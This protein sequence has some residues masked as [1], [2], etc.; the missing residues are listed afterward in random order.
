MSG[1]RTLI[2]ALRQVNG[3]TL[4]D[5]VQMILC[6]V[7]SVNEQEN[8]CD[9]IQ[10]SGD[11]EVSIPNVRLQAD[12]SDGILYL[13]AID[14]TVIVVISDYVT[15]FVAQYS[16]IDQILYDVGD[17]TIEVR[18]GKITLNSGLFGGLIKIV[19]MVQRMNI[20]ENKV[21]EIIAA[22]NLHTHPVTGGA[23]GLP[24]SLITGTLTPTV[25][26]DIENDKIVHG[27]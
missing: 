26:T 24:V 22:Y 5:K 10:I 15:P 25:R 11:A 13:P 21:N 16:E 3:T 1:T 9:V 27:D 14:S 6:T 4:T 12:V 20:I 2:E 18:E 19:Q 8:T 17:S 7:E 23:T